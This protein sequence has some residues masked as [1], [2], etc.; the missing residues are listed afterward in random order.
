MYEKCSH[1]GAHIAIAATYKTGCL[2]NVLCDIN[3]DT[4]TTWQIVTEN[5]RTKREDTA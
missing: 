3:A 4:S 1:C 5:R 2:A